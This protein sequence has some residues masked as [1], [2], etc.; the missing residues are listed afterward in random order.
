MRVGMLSFMLTTLCRDFMNQ[1]E[2]GTIE[3]TADDLPSFLYET[4][5][6]YNPDD[7]TTGLFRGFQLLRVTLGSDILFC[8]LFSNHYFRSTG[9]YLLGHHLP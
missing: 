9:I 4:G 7:E 3:I 6:V 5:T 2:D 8:L 1:V